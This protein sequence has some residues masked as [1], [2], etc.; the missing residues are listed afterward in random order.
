MIHTRVQ[1]DPD[2]TLSVRDGATGTVE[3]CAFDAAGEG[4]LVVVLTAQHWEQL[5]HGD[6]V[7]VFGS[8][9]L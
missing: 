8:P 3:L 5:C 4:S 2:A 1:L 7:R 6:N 9:E